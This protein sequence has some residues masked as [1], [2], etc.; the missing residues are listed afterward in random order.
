MAEVRAKQAGF[1]RLYESLAG[2][3]GFVALYLLL[4]GLLDHF[5]VSGMLKGVLLVVLLAPA[6]FA[7]M[8]GGVMACCLAELLLTAVRRL[9]PK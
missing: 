9:K 6:W 5:G 8:I 3:M 1:L 2:H 4:I 7:G